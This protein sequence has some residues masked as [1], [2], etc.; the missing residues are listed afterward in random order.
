MSS[1]AAT[2]QLRASYDA[3]GGNAFGCPFVILAEH[4]YSKSAKCTST[5]QHSSSTS[6]THSD[7]NWGTHIVAT[8]DSAH[9]WRPLAGARIAN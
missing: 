2:L 9:R 8:N 5:C 4:C 3:T 7:W 6:D 1:A